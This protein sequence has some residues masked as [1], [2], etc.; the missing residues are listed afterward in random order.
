MSLSRLLSFEVL[1]KLLDKN[2]VATFLNLFFF[3]VN[4]SL[5]FAKGYKIGFLKRKICGLVIS[6]NVNISANILL[7]IK[8]N[9]FSGIQ[10]DVMQDF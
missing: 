10:I 3:K 9:R 4:D 6:K 1:E 5:I 7:T 2:S 8:K